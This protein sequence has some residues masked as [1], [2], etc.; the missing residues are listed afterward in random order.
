MTGYLLDE[1]L[2]ETLVLPATLPVQHV[3]SL[4]RSVSDSSVW[5]HAKAHDLVIVSKDTDFSQRVL[6]SSPPPRV[7]HLRIGNMKRQE[8]E[9]FLVKAWPHIEALCPLYKLVELD[10]AGL[11][12]VV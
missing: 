9:Q 10:P 7:V 11:A 12:S 3:H 4:G 6:V 1:N 8:M 2:P 5:E